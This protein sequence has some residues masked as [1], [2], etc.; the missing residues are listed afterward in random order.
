M[1]DI[2]AFGIVLIALGCV[3]VFQ[4]V[5]FYLDRRRYLKQN[6]DLLDRLMAG[7][8]QTYA[9]GRR[10]QATTGVKLKE[11]LR[12]KKEPEQEEKEAEGLPVT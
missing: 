7:D 3:I 12:W 10:A 2:Y 1:M 8:Y 5:T 6:A 4:A 9:A 11:F